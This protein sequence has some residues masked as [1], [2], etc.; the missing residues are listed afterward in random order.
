MIRALLILWHLDPSGVGTATVQ[1]APSVDACY[2]IAAA[3]PDQSTSGYCTPL[4]T[5]GV[6]IVAKLLA[7]NRCTPRG[8][9]SFTCRGRP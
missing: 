9:D 7:A 8:T 1:F 5:E 4:T 6:N 2:R 3:R